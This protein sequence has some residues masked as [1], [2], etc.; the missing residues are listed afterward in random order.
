MTHS[1]DYLKI[2]YGGACFSLCGVS[3]A[4]PLYSQNFA[5]NAEGWVVNNDNA[6]TFLGGFSPPFN[7]VSGVGQV[8]VANPNGGPYTRWR[9]TGSEPVDIKMIDVPSGIILQLAYYLDVSDSNGLQNDQRVDYSVGLTDNSV[10]KQGDGFIRDY[11]FNFGFYNDA[12]GPGSGQ[13]RFVVS[14]SNNAPGNPKDQ[15]RDP[16]SISQSGW[17]IFRHKFYPEEQNV[18]AQLSIFGSDCSLV[19]SWAPQQVTVS[20]AG[21]RNLEASEPFYVRYGWIVNNNLPSDSLKMAGQVY[22][23][24]ISDE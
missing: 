14:T 17:Y 9:A 21:N 12:T 7:G 23:K 13:R 19:K 24:V 22:A 8:S 10:N 2:R 3:E 15:N 6:V 4:D 20:S 5:E 18:F 16:I 11:I 1:H